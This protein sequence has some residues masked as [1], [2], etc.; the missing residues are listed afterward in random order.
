V[1]LNTLAHPDSPYPV[2][3]N[4]R[5]DRPPRLP[6]GHGAVALYAWC[7]S[8]VKHPGPAPIFGVDGKP[9][10]QCWGEALI[11]LP[12]GEHLVEVQSE[13][14]MG[15]IQVTVRAGQF[16][17]VEYAAGLNGY[18]AG[19]LGI[20]PQRPPGR[21]SNPMAYFV[22]ILVSLLSCVAGAVIAGQAGLS[23]DGTAILFTVAL[24]AAVSVGSVAVYRHHGKPG[25]RPERKGVR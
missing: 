12:A 5:A 2:L 22:L 23:A 4:D 3:A 7:P 13:D 10:A 20:G 18:A 21:A 16:V 1:T 19:A 25:P 24:V 11:M 9:A 8:P 14:S 6:E 17:P 15:S